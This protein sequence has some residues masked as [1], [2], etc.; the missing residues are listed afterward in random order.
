VH[1]TTEFSQFEIVYGFNPL[2]PMDLIPLPIN[3]MLSSD[4][5]CKVQ[6]MKTLYESV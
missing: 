4:G 3:E 6:V 1:S 2:I 5:N